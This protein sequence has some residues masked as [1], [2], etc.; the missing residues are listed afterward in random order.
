MHFNFKILLQHNCMKVGCRAA[1][2][3]AKSKHTFT[4][5]HTN[6][7]RTRTVNTNGRQYTC[8]CVMLSPCPVERQSK[9]QN[10]KHDGHL[11][12][13]ASDCTVGSK[14]RLA[15]QFGSKGSVRTTRSLAATMSV[16]AKSC[17][18]AAITAALLELG[19]GTG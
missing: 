12:A 10:C 8:S 7:H 3:L 9:A 11:K 2:P 14:W 18:F 4:C 19:S 6:K 5:Q 13:S 17:A 1:Q 15:A 16:L